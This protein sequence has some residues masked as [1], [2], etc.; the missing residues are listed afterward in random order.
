[1][2]YVEKLDKAI[3]YCLCAYALTSCISGAL[4]DKVIGLGVLFGIL[5]CLKQRPK[6]DISKEYI[7]ALLVFFGVFFLLIFISEDMGRSAR[8]YWRYFNRMF[9]FL[10][11]LF[12][13]SSRKQIVWIGVCLL[14]SVTINNGYAIYKQI[15]LLQSQGIWGRASGFDKSVI[16]L[17]G[18]LLLTIPSLAI[19]LCSNKLQLMNKSFLMLALLISCITLFMNG[20]RIAWGIIAF[21]LLLLT[22]LFIKSWK[23]AV[24]FSC[25]GLIVC[26][27]LVSF[28]TPVHDRVM[29]IF[30]TREPSNRGHY[31]IARD[32]LRMIEDHL[33]LGVG[34]GRFQKVFNESYIS[35]QTKETDQM[36]SHAHNNTL[37]MLA[38]TGIVGLAAFWYMF[39]SFLVYSWQDWK[40]DENLPALIFFSATLA[41][42]LQ[43]ITDYSFGLHPVMKIYFL[44]LA[45]YLKYRTSEEIKEQTG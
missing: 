26:T 32:S 37:H 23:K 13:L 41:V 44:M 27:A 18:I 17:A 1:M 14:V 29:S 22:F 16:N 36:V 4:A 35:P 42:T 30:S 28:I 39:G 5:R 43:G 6:I 34:L 19:L 24:I 40:K 10:L 11:A 3:F 9:P 7:R 2:N 21:I 8:E 12:F 25:L 38:E 45:M 31:F 33:V 20:T 15:V